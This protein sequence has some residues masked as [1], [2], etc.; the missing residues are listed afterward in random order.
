MRIYLSSNINQYYKKR[1]LIDNILKISDVIGGVIPNGI[2]RSLYTRNILNSMS[3]I[4]LI[5]FNCE[6]LGRITP[7]IEIKTK[8]IGQQYKV[9]YIDG[10]I[11]KSVSY[12]TAYRY[13]KKFKGKII[14]L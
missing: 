8:I 6:L 5:N 14:K 7:D 1:H 3:E 13:K 4:D 12:M 2:N 11:S 10:T 9:L